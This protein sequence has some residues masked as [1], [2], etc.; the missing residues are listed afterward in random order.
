MGGQFLNKNTDKESYVYFKNERK[1]II[2]FIVEH[3]ISGVVFLSGD[4]HHTEIIKDESV[5]S[6]LGYSL[7][8]LTCSPLSAGP[9]NTAQ[10]AEF[11]N[12]MREPNTLVADN[13]FCIVAVSG[14]K[15]MRKL[16]MQCY[17]KYGTMRWEKAYT[18]NDFKSLK[19]QK[20][21]KTKTSNQN[22]K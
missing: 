18:E 16:T 19:A 20:P 2:D 4:R 13:N 11:N 15:N 1:K 5:K 14:P 7:M 3:Q 6:R 12:P 22:K 17:D 9:A 21:N 8:E 10:W